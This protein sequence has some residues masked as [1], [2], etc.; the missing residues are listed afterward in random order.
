MHNKKSGQITLSKAGLFTGFAFA[1]IIGGLIVFFL[2][3]NR[4]STPVETPQIVT[5]PPPVVAKPARKEVKKPVVK[6]TVKQT[7]PAEPRTVKQSNHFIIQGLLSTAGEPWAPNMIVVKVL[8][9]KNKDNQQ[10]LIGKET[11]LVQMSDNGLVYRIILKPQSKAYT[12]WNGGVEGN[13]GRI[14][15]FVDHQRDGR[16][17]PK[18]D[19]IIAVSK[20]L[21]RYR[22]GRFD[23]TILNEIQQQN[24]QKAGK[25]YVIVRN[26]PVGEGKMDW[27]VIGRASPFRLDLSAAETSLPGMYN[28]FLKLQ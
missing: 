5:A 18:K 14:I 13:V 28:T 9:L 12:N 8:W 1:A 27:K 22:T 15:A 17:T 16:L 11:G 6:E 25:G 19:K 3:S 26:E 10:F 4:E 20:E 2:T 7:K 21:V 24:I 23:K